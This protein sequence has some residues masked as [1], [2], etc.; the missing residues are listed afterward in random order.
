MLRTKKIT[1]FPIAGPLWGKYTK[2]QK[3]WKCFHIWSFYVGTSPAVWCQVLIVGNDITCN[4]SFPAVSA[5][6]IKFKRNFIFLNVNINSFRHK[7]APMQTILNDRKVDLL[8]VSESKLDSTFPDAQFNVDGFCI[9]RQDYIASTAGLLVYMSS[10]I[11]HRRL[12]Q[13]EI[14]MGGLNLCA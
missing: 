7:F 2:G 1:T 11:A 4:D 10:D 5:Y 6:R 8:V 14:N 13:L 3:C 12:V 9:Y